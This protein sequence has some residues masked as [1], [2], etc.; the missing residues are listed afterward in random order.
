MEYAVYR[1]TEEGTESKHPKGKIGISK[2]LDQRLY[3]HF[4][5][6]EKHYE[7]LCKVLGGKR[8]ALDVERVFQEYYGV[9]DGAV[10]W[11]T[12]NN[13]S[14]RQD[15]KDK[16]A[17][18]IRRTGSSR[19]ANNG[20][21]AKNSYVLTSPSGQTFSQEH[22]DEEGGWSKFC[23]NRGLHK[24]HLRSVAMGVQGQHKG[25]QCRFEEIR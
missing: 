19:G 3:Y 21:Y 14:K 13:P 1:L 16:I 7:V 6:N 20:R 15:V 9:V 11:A 2:N 5:K 17:A 25:W 8:E 10:L 12:T 23:K 18:T 24:G 4:G 22:F